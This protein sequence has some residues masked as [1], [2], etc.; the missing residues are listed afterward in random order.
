MRRILLLLV[1]LT[2]CTPAQREAWLT[3]FHRDPKAAVGWAV[4]DCGAL[5]TDDW[6]GDGVV[7]PEPSADSASSSVDGDVVDDQYP[8]LG[9]SCSEWSDDALAVGWS[10]EQWSTLSYI[11]NRESQCSPTAYNPS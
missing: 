10:A 3:W 11:M 1:V 7:E 9:G 4:D 5:C 6:D 8:T 2:S